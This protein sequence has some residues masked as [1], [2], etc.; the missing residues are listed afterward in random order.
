MAALLALVTSDNDT[1]EQRYQLFI[2]WKQTMDQMGIKRETLIDIV[3]DFL[4]QLQI[5]SI[6]KAKHVADILM[7]KSDDN[8]NDVDIDVWTLPTWKGLI[9]CTLVGQ[10]TP[11]PVP[12]S[13]EC[14]D[15]IVQKVE[16]GNKKRSQSHPT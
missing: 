12:L 16:Q 11:Y 7:T 2:N 1:V 9:A 14:L 5:D 15:L 8:Y 3:H 6:E 13:Q 10:Q 4:L